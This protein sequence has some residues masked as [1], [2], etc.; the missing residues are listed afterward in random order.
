M[1]VI[2]R[3]V[4]GAHHETVL[5]AM[6]SGTIALRRI[7]RSMKEEAPNGRRRTLR[8]SKLN[9]NAGSHIDLINYNDTCL[10]E[11]PLTVCILSNM[12]V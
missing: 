8:V 2:E 11:P 3:N 1:P 12:Y 6:K 5:A 7:F 10:S 4:F 9:I